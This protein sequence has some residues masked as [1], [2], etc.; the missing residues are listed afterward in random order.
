MTNSREDG[1]CWSADRQ[2]RRKGGSPRHYCCAVVTAFLGMKIET[3]EQEQGGCFEGRG[4]GG[5][6]LE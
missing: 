2:R 3:R 4:W 1:G 5:F 6:E